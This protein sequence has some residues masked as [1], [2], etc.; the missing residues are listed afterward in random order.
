MAYS[1]LIKNFQRVRD[2]MRAF[3]VYG[4]QSRDEYNKKSGRS[5]DN[6]RR[7]IESWLGDYMRFSKSE[8]GK[9][10]FLSIDSRA[11][12]GNPLYKA[13]K[14][15]SF[16]DRDIT[17]HFILFDILHSPD[18]ALSVPELCERIDIYLS[19]FDEPIEFDESTVRK[20]L[21]E[22]VNEGIVQA[23]KDGRKVLYSRTKED[24]EIP[25]YMLQFF[26][27]V[28]PCGVVG[29]FLL[30]K[31][32][33]SRHIFNF[34]HH[35]I[36]SALDSDVLCDLF[37]AIREHREVTADNY[38]PR[39]SGAKQVS[40]V[41]LKVLI[42]AQGGRQYL[43]GYSR[44]Y[45]QLRSYRVDY[46][47]NIKITDVAEDFNSLRK[48]LKRNEKHMWGVTLRNSIRGYDKVEMTVKIGDNEEYAPAAYVERT[49]PHRNDESEHQRY[50]SCCKMLSI[51]NIELSLWK[52]IV[53]DVILANS[54]RRFRNFGIVRNVETLA[55]RPAP[56]LDSGTSLWCNTPI[57]ELKQGELGF[58]SKQSELS[59]ARQMLLI[60]DMP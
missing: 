43:I 53:C 44:E 31:Q 50:V 9:N 32:T 28:L 10:V 5:Y 20:K 7:R 26:S 54:D 4:F 19:G 29:S 55:C 45:D 2:Y 33:E 30:D 22:Y 8:E 57:E 58:H 23:Q 51:D 16:T 25:P 39:Y 46:L 37:L 3:Y 59:P 42:S 11:M 24:S 21:K 27:E 1:E 15:S 14:T 60:E 18:T 41:P 13:F 40:F 6:E 56:M 38:S 17:L 12:P 48:W 52:M 34:K 36:L 47:S 49:K 35:Y